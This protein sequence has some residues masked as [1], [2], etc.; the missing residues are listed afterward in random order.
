MKHELIKTENYLL[1]VSDEEIKEGEFGLADIQAGD[2]Y[3]IV[4]YNSAFAKHYY[5]KIIAHLPL[6]GEEYLDGVDVL[7]EIDFID[8]SNKNLYYH[9]QVMNPYPVE[10]YSYAVYEK[11]FVEGYNKAKET[12]KYT[13][14]DMIEFAVWRSITDFNEPHTPLGEFKIWE[15]LKQPK[16]PIAFDSHTQ[17]F[18]DKNNILKQW[19]GPRTII[20]S[21]GRTEWVG[22]YLF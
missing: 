16:L 19:D 4:K 2:F 21:E 5:K 7:P 22:K 8:E 10:E 17:R 11:G 14:E 15:S 18:A 12:Y 20:N 1:V 13:E 6:N 9:K 3:G